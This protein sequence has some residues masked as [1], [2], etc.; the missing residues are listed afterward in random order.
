[1][2]IRKIFSLFAALLPVKAFASSL[3]DKATLSFDFYADNTEVE[4][5]S[6]TF[7]FFKTITRKFLIGIKMRIDAISAASIRNG[8]SP[9]RTDAVTG[10]TRR[11]F[12]DVRYAPTLL[13]V[14]DDGDNTFTFGIYYSTERDYTGRSIFANYTRQLNLQNTAVSVGISQSFDEWN[15]AF[16]RNLPRNDRKERKVDV[17]ITQLLSPTSMVQ[18][19]Y[20]NIY[21]EGFLSSP[22]HYI[23]RNDFALFERYPETR[24]GHAF[25]FRFVKLLNE[26]TSVNF[27][28]RYYTDD[29]GI[30]SHTFDVKLLRDLSEDFTVGIRYR[31]YTQGKADFAKDIQDYSLTDKYIAVD[32][33]MSSFNSNTTGILFIKKFGLKG[34]K[35]KGAINYYWTSSNDYIKHW[36]GKESIKAWFGSISLDYSF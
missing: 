23:L 36:Y 4:V 21:S 10:A 6:S 29:W 11:T 35:L 27:Y 20:S 30:D 34:I 14:Y 31:Y 22:Y 28:Y 18:L 13:G 7:G 19:S 26:P 33:R 9:A 17:S 2:Q 5:Y 24:Q 3:E 32:Y 25:T 12:D 15:P 8:G 16:K 1:M